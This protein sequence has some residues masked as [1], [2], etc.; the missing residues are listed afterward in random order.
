MLKFHLKYNYTSYNNAIKLLP[1]ITIHKKEVE[2]V[3]KCGWYTC[4]V[5]MDCMLYLKFNLEALGDNWKA[6]ETEVQGIVTVTDYEGPLQMH[7]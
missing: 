2:I 7:R 4:D 1:D 5:N 6:T 3:I